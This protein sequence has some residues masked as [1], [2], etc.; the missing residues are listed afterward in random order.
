MAEPDVTGRCWEAQTSYAKHIV[1]AA[2][3]RAPVSPG[4][5]DV[6]CYREVLIKKYSPLLKT[7]DALPLSPCRI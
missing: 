2:V 4:D 3:P 7:R 5:T 1:P 6:W